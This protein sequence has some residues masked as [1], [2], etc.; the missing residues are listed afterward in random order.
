MLQCATV[1]ENSAAPIPDVTKHGLDE[2]CTTQNSNNDMKALHDGRW[3]AQKN[4]A[5]PAPMSL[6]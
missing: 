1:P 2:A 5:S 4:L 3:K 6:S